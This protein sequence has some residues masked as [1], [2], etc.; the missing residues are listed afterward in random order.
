MATREVLGWRW[1]TPADVRPADCPLC[2]ARVESYNMLCYV[3]C[4]APPSRYSHATKRSLMPLIAHVRTA[5]QWPAG[6]ASAWPLQPAQSTPP[7]IAPRRHRQSD[8]T[9]GTRSPSALA[10][11]TRAPHSRMPHSHTAPTHRT[12]ACAH[13]LSRP[14]HRSCCIAHTQVALSLCDCCFWDWWPISQP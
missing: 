14:P 6:R 8:T 2:S 5:W 12:Q 4:H 7:S 10:H 1:V 3:L 13:F 11:S 9:P